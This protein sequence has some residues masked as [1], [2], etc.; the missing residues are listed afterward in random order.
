[1][2][3]EDRWEIIAITN[4]GPGGDRSN[5]RRGSTRQAAVCQWRPTSAS[6]RRRGTGSAAGREEEGRV[7]AVGAYGAQN[8]RGAASSRG[9]AVM[10]SR[11]RGGQQ[12]EIM[13]N[14]EAV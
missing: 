4:G 9:S 13:A 3:D 5:G 8:R 6:G 11:R 2:Q 7:D 12:R 1:V 14:G 10:A